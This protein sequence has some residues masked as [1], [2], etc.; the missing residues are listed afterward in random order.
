MI[1]QHNRKRSTDNRIQLRLEQI[2]S[3]TVHQASLAFK[4]VYFLQVH[5][6]VPLG[7]NV[8]LLVLDYSSHLAII[9]LS[10]CMPHKATQ[11][12]EMVKGWVLVVTV[13]TASRGSSAQPNLLTDGHR[14]NLYCHRAH[15]LTDG[16][17]NFWCDITGLLKD[18]KS[19][20]ANVDL[21]GTLRE[22]HPSKWTYGHGRCR[23][24]NQ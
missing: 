22:M 8:E 17:R 11:T 15:L 6:A 10:L 19:Y 7:D 13:A 5:V 1:L 4:I 24:L 16:H 3:T 2:V 9:V 23:G 12:S 18:E 14:K 20:E 21:E